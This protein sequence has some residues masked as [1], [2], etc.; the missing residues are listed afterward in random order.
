MG[1]IQDKK[2]I[3]EV[4]IKREKHNL[5][6]LCKASRQADEKIRLLADC[7]DIDGLIS[8]LN[9]D[10]F[11]YLPNFPHR[12]RRGIT[13]WSK[14][15]KTAEHFMYDTCNTKEVYMD[16]P[17]EDQYEKHDYQRR[18]FKS[19]FLD[20]FQNHSVV[21]E[22][23]DLF[24]ITYT[25]STDQDLIIDITT[26]HPHCIT[27]T[28]HEMFKVM[29]EWQWAYYE[30]E[31]REPMAAFCNNVLLHLGLDVR[32]VEHD[33][34]VKSLMQ[35]PDMYV[36]QFL[37]GNEIIRPA[38]VDPEEPLEF[39]LWASQ[40]HMYDYKRDKCHDIYESCLKIKILEKKLSQI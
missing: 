13:L 6:V 16:T 39:K 33:P 17:L 14:Q 38:I 36:A 25:E 35:L 8:Y 9:S 7:Y 21:I 29:L 1:T 37:A 22:K 18:L 19:G 26:I 20:A 5:T 23:D 4:N 15:M 27:H 32:N 11:L 28:V 24:A 12:Y 40:K 3:L 10:D 30:L 2:N 31:S 34:V